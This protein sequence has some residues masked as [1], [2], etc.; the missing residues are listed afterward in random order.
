MGTAYY[1]CP[2]Q[3]LLPLGSLPQGD[4]CGHVCEGTEQKL[5]EAERTSRSDFVFSRKK[6]EKISPL[7]E[8]D[9][10]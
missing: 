8:V 9:V 5:V 1:L 10:Q 4:Q 3:W 6:N 2:S 7:Y